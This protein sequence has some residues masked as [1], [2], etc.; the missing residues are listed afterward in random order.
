MLG[1]LCVCLNNIKSQ[2]ELGVGMCK[3]MQ[4]IFSNEGFE[5]SVVLVLVD[6]QVL[7]GLDV[8]QCDVLC[9]LLLCLLIQIFMV[10]VE[11]IEGEVNCSW[12][13]QVYELFKV[14]IGQQY[15][16]NFNLD[17]DVVL[18]DIVVIFGVSGSIVVFNKDVLGMLVIQCGNLLE[19][20][21]WVG[22]GIILFNELVVKYGNWVSGGVVGVVLQD[23]IIFEL[24]LLLVIGVIEYMIEIDG[25]ILCYCNMLLQWIIMQYLNLGQV[26][27]VKVIVVVLDGCIV[28]VF[29]VVGVNGFS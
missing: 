2:G 16:F 1:K 19:V 25:Q 15:F 24:L 7:I 4:D 8:V 26:F 18:S 29:N 12:G 23:I 6:E 14:C 3:L 13:V 17:V 9:L 28:E 10:L 5:L 27:G 20:C 22:M 21:C 11:F